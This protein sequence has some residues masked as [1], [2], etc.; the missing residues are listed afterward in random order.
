MSFTTHSQQELIWLTSD[1]LDS[2]QLHHGFSTRPGGVS[3]APWDSLNLGIAR[4]DDPR[5]VEENYRRFC[6]AIGTDER[7]VVLSC[8]VHE[9]HIRHVTAADAGKGLWRERDYQSADALITDVPGLSLVVF[10][11]DCNIILLYDPRRQAIGAVHAGWRGVALG[12]VAKTVREMQRVFGT[13]PGDLRC[14]IGPAIGPCCF[15]TKDDVPDALH[16][17]LG[18]K[19]D[20]Y[21]ER[22]GEKWHI[23]LKAINAQWLCDAGVRAEQIDI[24]PH[25]T[26]CMPQ[27]YWSH[28]K[29]GNA[30]GLQC[31]LIS[32]EG[33]DLFS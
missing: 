28:R 31:G 16:D 23:D 3:P 13:D 24:C 29:M 30:R 9:D 5:R 10:S 4:G 15:E 19:A 17:A 11:A 26:A 12:L 6:A 1:V 14:A 7:K 32:L 25:C 21:M 8:Q 18:Q 27:L 33:G 22:R 2:P 20:P